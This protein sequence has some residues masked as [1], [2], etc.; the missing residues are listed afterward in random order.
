[1][2]DLGAFEPQSPRLLDDQATPTVR[3][4]RSFTHSGR[5]VAVFRPG[6]ERA[7][8]VVVLDQDDAELEIWKIDLAAGTVAES[9]TASTRPAVRPNGVG[10]EGFGFSQYD[11]ARTRSLDI[12]DTPR[13]RL[14]ACFLDPNLNA[15][16][17]AFDAFRETIDR[18]ESAAGPVIE[19][20]ATSL[21]IFHSGNRFQNAFRIAY[22][23]DFGVNADGIALYYSIHI[24]EFVNT[25]L[26]RY[27]YNLDA[28]DA[29]PDPGGSGG[30]RQT[31][32]KALLQAGSVINLVLSFEYQPGVFASIESEG[33]RPATGQID[34]GFGESEIL[35]DGLG[36]SVQQYVG[37]SIE[38]RTLDESQPIV[39]V[40]AQTVDFNRF[41]RVFRASPAGQI[42]TIGPPWTQED[43]EQP[44]FDQPDFPALVFCD[45]EGE[46][47]LVDPDGPG[48]FL[49][50]IGFTDGGDGFSL[51]RASYDGSRWGDWTERV[52]FPS[53]GVAS[54]APRGLFVHGADDH[55]LVLVDF[56][57]TATLPSGEPRREA[58]FLLDPCEDG[59]GSLSSPAA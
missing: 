42:G 46:G 8:F 17:L 4:P 39:K 36:I 16:I 18:V 19:Q 3:L 15:R 48:Q 37:N 34:N 12:D 32:A 25:R 43:V 41:I 40:V 51:Y 50:A 58:V 56:D 6:P 1:M 20:V 10:N 45:P 23:S 53:E 22:F 24:N 54:G 38:I 11:V 57:S 28:W 55:V 49:Y 27:R 5:N 13:P 33:L 35:I 7:W 59:Q 21:D 47:K 44:E 9:T 52:V 26:A 14:F 29:L 31:E 30:V 2:A